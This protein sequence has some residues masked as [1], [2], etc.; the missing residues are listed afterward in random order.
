MTL[1]I[2]GAFHSTLCF[3]ARASHRPQALSKQ[4]DLLNSFISFD[5][6]IFREASSCKKYQ[7]LLE[8]DLTHTRSGSGEVLVASP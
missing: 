1:E 3:T 5:L 8:S 7:E 2:L 4:C 6:A